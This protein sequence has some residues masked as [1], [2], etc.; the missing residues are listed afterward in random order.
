MLVVHVAV[1][2][3]MPW[4]PHTGQGVFNQSSSSLTGLPST[5]PAPRQDAGEGCLGC[6]GVLEVHHGAGDLLACSHWARLRAFPTCRT[7]W[8]EECH[9]AGAGLGSVSK[10]T[11]RHEV[12]VGESALGRI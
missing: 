10:P 7:A 3:C 4:V 1:P 12:L 8:L 6:V 5:A 9:G 11:V 2:G